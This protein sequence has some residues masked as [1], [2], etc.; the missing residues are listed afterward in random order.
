MNF[1]ENQLKTIF[2]ATD[3]LTPATV[4]AGK[5][6]II[7][8]NEKLIAKVEFITTRTAGV[9]EGLKITIINKNDGIIDSQTILFYEV[10]GL[11]GPKKDRKLHIWEDSSGVNW[12][13]YNPTPLE[14][15]PIGLCAEKYIS[16][17]KESTP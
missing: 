13:A 10:I 15:S 1:F 9:Y 12:F 3:L 6:M 4:F 16:L 8:L 2:I 17:F 11:I 14:L 5:A 7:P